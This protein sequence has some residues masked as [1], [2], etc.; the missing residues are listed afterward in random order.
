MKPCVVSEREKQLDAEV[1]RR[2]QEEYP[3][4]EQVILALALS[5]KSEVGDQS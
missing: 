1:E 2:E 3:G 4:Y 5:G